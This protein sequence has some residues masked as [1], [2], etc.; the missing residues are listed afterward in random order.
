MDRLFFASVV[1]QERRDEISKELA[2]RHMLNEAE[3]NLPRVSRPKRLVWRLTPVVI[4]I[5][6]IALYLIG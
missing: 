4:L 6:L 5:S 1:A 3:G 2:V